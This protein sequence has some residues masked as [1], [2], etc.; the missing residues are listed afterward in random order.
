MAANNADEYL[1]VQKAERA[2]DTNRQTQAMSELQEALQLPQPPARIE[3]LRHQH[4]AGH[5][6]GRLHGRLCQ[7]HAAEKRLQAL[8]NPWQGQP[9]R[10][11]RLRQHARDVAPSLPACGGRTHRHR[12]RQKGAQQRRDLAHPARSGHRRRRQG[13]TGHRRGGPGGIRSL[14]KIPVV[15]LA[16]REEEIFRPGLFQTDL[17]DSV[18]ARRCIWSSASATRRI[19]SPSPITAICVARSRPA[20]NST[21]CAASVPSG[22]RRC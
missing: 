4:L 22:A 14:D 7:G 3:C 19:V 11:G 20:P 15:G 18:A 16:K 21:M 17:A 6:H 12:S 13:P 5:Q 2:A 1:R 10:A 9:G 8:Q